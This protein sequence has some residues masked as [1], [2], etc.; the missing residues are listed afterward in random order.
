MTTI[1]RYLLGYKTITFNSSDAE[2]IYDFLYQSRIT[3]WG[4]ISAEDFSSINISLSDFEYFKKM[5]S[6]ANLIA[7][8]SS[9]KGLPGILFRYKK[10]VGFWT[11]VCLFFLI[12]ALSSLFVWDIRVVGEDLVSE[13]EIIENLEKEGVFVGRFIPSI[14]ST[15]VCNSFLSNNEGISWMS[16]NPK[17]N[18]IYVEII[19]TKKEEEENKIGKYANIVA[20]EDAVIEEINPSRGLVVVKAGKT[21]KKGDLLIS[22]VY[23]SPRKYSFVYAD[24]VVFGRVSR[25]IK[26]EIPLSQT[27]KEHKKPKKS[28]ISIN[29]FNFTINIFRYSGKMPIKYDTIY[30]KEQ[31]VIF[32]TVKLPIYIN[33]EEFIEYEDVLISISESEAV[34]L[35]FSRLEAELCAA[36]SDSDIVSKNIEGYFTDDTYVLTCKAEC[37][38]NI[39]VPLEFQAD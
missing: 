4:Y 7:K 3:S 11:G 30:R 26:I 8:E 32:D 31:I 10:R 33:S 38:K 27:K 15:E 17:G 34:R 25:D 35:A 37:V 29:F 39:A 36:T 20:S 5:S 6:S 9:T 14:K 18:V 1:F 2:E 12:L 19:E 23:S 16:I 24:G 22:G 13:N 21:V 28:N